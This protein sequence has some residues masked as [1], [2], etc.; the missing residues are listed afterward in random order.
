METI[1]GSVLTHLDQITTKVNVEILILKVSLF[2]HVTLENNIFYFIQNCH[3]EVLQVVFLSFETISLF[4][5]ETAVFYT[6][7]V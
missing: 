5:V 4:P 2:N 3:S 1:F 6:W 7:Y